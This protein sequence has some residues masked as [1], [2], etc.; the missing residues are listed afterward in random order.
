MKSVFM[1]MR[2]IIFFLINF[3]MDD[4]IKEMLVDLGLNAGERKLEEVLLAL[5]NKINRL[6][7]EI[8]R[9]KNDDS[10]IILL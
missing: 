10:F 9:M 7:K 4:D 2:R 5:Y 1:K 3:F 8:K 6:E